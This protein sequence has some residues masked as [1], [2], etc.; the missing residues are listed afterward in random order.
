MIMMR[1]CLYRLYQMYKTTMFAL[2]L[3]TFSRRFYREIRT[4]KAEAT[5][6]ISVRRYM[7]VDFLQ[8]KYD[9]DPHHKNKQ[10]SL[11]SSDE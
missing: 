3:T 5:S 4:S 9:S 1:V 10:E 11:R 8:L 2:G 6:Y 7:H